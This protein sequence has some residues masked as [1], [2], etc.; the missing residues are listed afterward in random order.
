[1]KKSTKG[2]LIQFLIFIFISFI[3]FVCLYYAFPNYFNLAFIIMIGFLAITGIILLLH[4]RKYKTNNPFKS[5][6][7]N[8][9]G[10]RILL[11]LFAG[12]HYLFFL[13]TY[14]HKYYNTQIWYPET[15]ECIFGNISESILFD[16]L[17]LLNILII[18]F[19]GIYCAVALAA[20]L[21]IINI[22]SLIIGRKK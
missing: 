12:F 10:K 9:L 14:S 1:M 18:K 3:P 13:G 6:K 21:I 4:E 8:K 16:I 7:K 11:G 20:L 2:G 15:L 22:I 17:L 5:S 19:L